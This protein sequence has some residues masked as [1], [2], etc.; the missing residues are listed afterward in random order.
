ADG[1]TSIADRRS[2]PG[3]CQRQPVARRRLA[4]APEHAADLVGIAVGP[5]LKDALG[6]EILTGR[7]NLV[8]D[9]RTHGGTVAA[10]TKALDG[11]A[12]IELRDGLVRGVNVAQIVRNAAA[13]LGRGPAPAAGTAAVSE[14]TDFSELSGSFRIQHGVAHNDDLRARTPLLHV[15]GS[16]QV[17]LVAGR[18]DYLLKATVTDTLAGQ[19]GPQWQ[20]LRGQTV[21]VRLAGPFGAIGY[22]VDAARLVQ[23]LARKKLEEKAREALPEAQQRLLEKFRGLLGK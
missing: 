16:G 18:L 5:L 23:D 4:A 14:T 8:V 15:S 22:R 19:G 9:L 6:K 13:L 7:G 11:Q 10:L 17:D 3:P 12:R 20:A 1:S 21:P 2:L